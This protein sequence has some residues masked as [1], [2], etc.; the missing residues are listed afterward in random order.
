MGDA[1]S[2]AFYRVEGVLLARPSAAAA[3]WIASNAQEAMTRLPRLGAIALSAPFLVPTPWRDRSTATRMA[4][5]ALRGMSEDR[6]VVLGEEYCRSVLDRLIPVGVDLLERSRRA[7]DTVVLVSD[8]VDAVIRPL[9][10]HLG[11]DEVVCN[12]L[13]FRDGRCTGRL[14][15]PVVGG[16]VNAV[17]IRAWAS[18]RGIS[19]STSTAYGRTTADSTLLGAIGR[20]CTVN[21]DRE[22][23]LLA[24]D[25][26]WPVVEG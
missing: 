8:C 17:R 10:E 20:P 9:A 19:L 12:R 26:D 22:L 11:A 3:A 13:E 14:L 23:R 1:E 4:W 7:G 15:D 21:P 18:E 6:L 24:R 5:M 25:L 2:A 16:V